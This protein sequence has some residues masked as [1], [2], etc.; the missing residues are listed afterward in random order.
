MTENDGTKNSKRSGGQS[1]PDPANEGG[2][3]PA[4]PTKDKPVAPKS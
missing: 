1:R 3:K 4:S 2:A